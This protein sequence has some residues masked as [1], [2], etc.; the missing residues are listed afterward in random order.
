MWHI[1]LLIHSENTEDVYCAANALV[2]IVKLVKIIVAEVN[3][4][5]VQ[6]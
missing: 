2:S 3:N 6:W 4:Y 1:I 5:T